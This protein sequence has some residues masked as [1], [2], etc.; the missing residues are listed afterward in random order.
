FATNETAMRVR[1][2]DRQKYRLTDVELR[3]NRRCLDA[4]AV[5]GGSIIVDSIKNASFRRG[6]NEVVAPGLTRRDK[7]NARCEIHSKD[8]MTRK[9]AKAARRARICDIN[10]SDPIEEVENDFNP[11]RGD[12]GSAGPS[13]EDQTS[14]KA[15]SGAAQ[16]TGDAQNA[17]VADKRGAAAAGADGDTEPTTTETRVVSES[18]ET[19]EDG[20]TTT[21]SSEELTSETKKTEFKDQ[22]TIVT[23]TKR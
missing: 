15:K 20:T 23:T 18:R 14:A 19:S 10:E 21:K 1:L 8:K 9:F 2:D 3:D 17:D 11:D 5:K 13:T 16:Q 12:V 22:S 4:R 6:L 7:R